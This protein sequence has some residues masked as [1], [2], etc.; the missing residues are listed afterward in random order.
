MVNVSW[1]YAD[2]SRMIDHSLL[3]PETTLE[4]FET[5]C[6]LA[7]AYQTGSVCIQ[8]HYLARCTELLSGSGV[9]SSTVIGFPHGGHR[10]A[11]KVAEARQAIADG[12]E[13]LDVVCNIS[14]VV[15]GDWDYV[16]SDLEAVIELAHAAHAKVKVI[17]ENCYLN[18]PQKIR[19]CEICTELRADWVKTSTGYGSSGSTLED[20]RLMRQY[21]GPDVQV[22]AAGGIRDLDALLA[23]RELGVTRVGASATQAMLDECRRRLQLPPL[24]F[25]ATVAAP[26][27]Y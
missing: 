2:I 26:A 23:C 27:G 7:A 5:G 13:E 21:S 11:V 8:P 19:L 6:R 9:K 25:V 4:A 17:F 10:T 24:E 12:G 16:R 15:S 20:L 14:R 22:K 3:R 1:N 18:A